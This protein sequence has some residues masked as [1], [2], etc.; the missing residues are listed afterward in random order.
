MRLGMAVGPEGAL[1]LVAPLPDDETRWVDLNAME[2][3][4]LRRL[5]EGEPERLAA[6]L[7]PSELQG[8]LAAGPRGMARV[9]QTLAYASKWYRRGDLPEALA[10]HREAFR[11][12]ACLPN[13]LNILDAA[14]K[15]LSVIVDGP[16]AAMLSQPRVT[17][18]LIGQAGGRPAGVCL[19]VLEPMRLILGRWLAVG[20]NWTGHLQLRS[21]EHLRT[22][23]LE[24]WSDLV[25]GTLRSGD[26]LILPPPHWKPLPERVEGTLELMA[27]WEKAILTVEGPLGHPGVQ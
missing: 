6:V 14:G 24:A 19:A 20:M 25:L 23:P 27:P 5:G 3:A 12:Q 2:T 15:R 21:G 10:P 26:V 8:V 4:R 13:P 18:A 11:S 9:Q 17:L 1:R 16:G 7:V 22:A